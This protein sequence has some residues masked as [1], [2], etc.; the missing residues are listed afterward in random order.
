MQL[1]ANIIV[2]MNTNDSGPALP[3]AFSRCT[4]F[5]N[6][7]LPFPEKVLQP[8]ANVT[9]HSNSKSRP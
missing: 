5:E 2:V 7:T 4:S 1:P 8:S 6:F 9:A 3:L